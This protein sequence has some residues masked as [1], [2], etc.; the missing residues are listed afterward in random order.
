MWINNQSSLHDFILLGFSDRPWLETPFF[1][2]F[3]V[4][5][6]FSLFGNISII[7]VS[8]LDPQLDSP[9]YFFVSNLSFLDLCYTTSTVPEMLVNL[10]GAE[11]IISY[12]GCVA[13]L[14]IFLALGSTESILLAI[15][16]FDRYAAICKPLRYPVIMNQRRCIHM[17]AGTWISGFA[18]SV[19]QSTLTVVAPR[20]GQRVLDHF[21]CEVPALLKLACIDTGVNETELNVLG[22]SLLLVPLTLI[23]GTYVFIAQAV[24]RI[25]SAESRWKAFNTCASHL[26]VVSLF[27]FTAISMYVQ[28]PSS[29]SRDRGKVMALFYGI[30][31]PT[32][33]P[34]IYTL[35]NK[36]VK[37]AL[38]RSLTKEFWIKTR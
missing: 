20:C 2:I 21:F 38:R 33:N 17:A 5:Y 12:G 36:D 24:M 27:Y 7:L 23:L 10:R 25:R 22:A 16:A 30:V 6:I 31:T 15:M 26:L 1:V 29:Y 18:N 8:C 35:R 37:A 14:Y 19:V 28:P 32:L 3:L 4:A 11:K 13:Q 34:F 9:M